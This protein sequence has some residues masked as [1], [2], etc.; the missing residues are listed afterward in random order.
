M[1]CNLT[2][3]VMGFLCFGL[4]YICSA[5]SLPEDEIGFEILKWHFNY[6]PK[7]ETKQWVKL[8][9]EI[10]Q[11]EFV[12]QGKNY[13]TTYLTDGARLS[14]E[15]DLSKELPLTIKYF[16]DERYEKY[17]VQYFNKIVVFKNE[18]TY[19]TMSVKS[20]EKGEETLSFD[21]HYVPVDFALISS[22]D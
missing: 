20:K 19:Y 6:Y 10:L 8:E 17:K 18:L 13:K 21:E 3:T 12:F 2:K 16:L 22:I 5:Q 7:S 4:T 14:E 15:V 11:A 9:D 1:K